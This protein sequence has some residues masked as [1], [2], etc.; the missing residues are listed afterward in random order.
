MKFLRRL[1]TPMN[2]LSIVWVLRI[3]PKD[4]N[5]RIGQDMMIFT[6]QKFLRD[7]WLADGVCLR[8]FGYDVD[9]YVRIKWIF[10]CVVLAPRRNPIRQ[11]NL[12]NPT[13]PPL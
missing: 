5:A 1:F 13:P 7:A 6:H 11:N 9:E 2:F 4:P 10:P 12:A 8:H 3:D